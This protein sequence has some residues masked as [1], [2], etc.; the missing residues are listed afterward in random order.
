[1]TKG[2]VT[3]IE[4]S[5]TWKGQHG[6][7]DQYKVEIDDN[8]TILAGSTNTPHGKECKFKAGEPCTFTQKDDDYGSKFTWA[9]PDYPPKTGGLNSAVDQYEAKKAWLPPPIDN[10]QNSIIRQSSLKVATDI[11]LQTKTAINKIDP[12]QET[13]VDIKALS[14]KIESFVKEV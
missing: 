1:M 13:W 9:N 5:H 10:R 4:F 2:T 6:D 11:I 8:E 14:I 7:M 3:K 12:Y